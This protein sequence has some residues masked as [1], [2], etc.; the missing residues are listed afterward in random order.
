HELVRRNVVL[1]RLPGTDMSL[2]SIRRHRVPLGVC[3]LV[4]AAWLLGGPARVDSSQGVA[5]LDAPLGWLH[6][7]TV[8]PG[9]I[10]APPGLLRLTR[11]PTEP[12]T[13]NFHAGES[14]HPPLV[15]REGI[16]VTASGTI[17]YR[18]DEERALE[19]H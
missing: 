6:P 3:L 14:R 1:V 5:V 4:A 15:T 13:L 2:E 18:I 19:V 7:R 16:A 12:I 11:Y 10:L 8:R 17:R 9:W